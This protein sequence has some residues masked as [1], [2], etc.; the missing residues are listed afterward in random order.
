MGNG[1]VTEA[2]S[3]VM[4]YAVNVKN[5]KEI[6][7]SYAIDNSASGRVLQKLGFQY[8]KEIVYECSG[9]ELVTKGNYCSFKAE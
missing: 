4:R 8:V 3:A 9:G 7:A 1:Y 2:M 5:I 6:A